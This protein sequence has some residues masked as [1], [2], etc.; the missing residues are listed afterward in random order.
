M[1]RALASLCALD[2]HQEK[3]KFWRVGTSRLNEVTVDDAATWRVVQAI[4]AIHDKEVLDDALV[5]DHKGD[6]GL[7]PCLVIHL[8]AS[9]GELS[10]LSV[11]Y[12]LSLSCADTIA[13]DND[14]RG[15]VLIVVLGE[16]LDS[17]LECG[18][19]LHV[20]NFLA[21]FLDEEV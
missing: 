16:L 5:D 17:F 6:L 3:V 9:L 7:D 20:H 2:R 14:I 12:V 21:L 4:V 18:L 19:H 1:G 15:E 13:I 8:V 10:H 11:D